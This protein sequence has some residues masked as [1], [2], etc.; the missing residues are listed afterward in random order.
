M[1][2]FFGTIPGFGF[3]IWAWGTLIPGIPDIPDIPGTFI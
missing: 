1:C 3:L 2:A